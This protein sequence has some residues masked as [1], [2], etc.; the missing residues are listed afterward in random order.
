MVHRGR[1]QHHAG[2]G[3]TAIRWHSWR[4]RAIVGGV[5][6][7]AAR[8]AQKLLLH[9]A[10]LRLGDQT[11]PDA[12]LIGDDEDG[13]TGGLEAA[14][15]IGYAGKDLDQSGIGAVVGFLHEGAVAIEEDGAAP[16][17]RHRAWSRG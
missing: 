14:E 1:R 11:P 6:R 8:L 17:S 7:T 12:A 16:L 10:I 13:E 15:P 3:L 5:D 9:R 4:V 2:I